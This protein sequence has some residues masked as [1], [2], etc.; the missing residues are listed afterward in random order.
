MGNFGER[1]WGISVSAINNP[2]GGV[3]TSENS[4]FEVS[5][6]GLTHNGGR[7]R[8]WDIRKKDRWQTLRA[9]AWWEVR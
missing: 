7:P 8:R 3:T 4:S 1:Q 9:D 2:P 6:I 5:I